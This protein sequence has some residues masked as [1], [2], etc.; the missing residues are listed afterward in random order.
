M[1]EIAVKDTRSVPGQMLADFLAEELTA[2]LTELTRQ[3]WEPDDSAVAATCNRLRRIRQLRRALDSLAQSVPEKVPT[4]T[5]LVSATFLHN[6]FQALTE[7]R[8]ECLVYATGPEDG[9]HIFALTRLVTFDLA[10]R[11]AVHAVPDPTSQMKAL[12]AL[13]ENGERLLATLHSHP[14]KGAGATAPSTVDLSTQAGLEK[15]GYPAI[16]VIFSRNGFVRFYTKN[17]TFR[18]VVSGAGARQIE[19]HLFQLTSV[20]SKPIFFRRLR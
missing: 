10:E 12:T 6:T 7:T 15:L 3:I 5:Y 2:A 16:G 20:N 18:V 11:S 1:S 14:G 17:R 13:E 9:K 4:P 19:E 8:D